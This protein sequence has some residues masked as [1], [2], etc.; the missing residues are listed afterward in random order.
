MTVRTILQVIPLTILLVILSLVTDTSIAP[1]EVAA[2]GTTAATCDVPAVH[3]DRANWKDDKS[4]V[5]TTFGAVWVCL[6]SGKG[7]SFIA[8]GTA[9]DGHWAQ[10]LVEDMSGVI[11]EMEVRGEE[12]VVIDSST[13]PRWVAIAFV[14]DLVT[15][16]QDRNLQIDNFAIH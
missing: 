4:I 6:P 5:M 8:R 15:E 13:D 3:L 2:I 10:I 9:A 1:L 7:V 11:V 14:N 12:P 16:G